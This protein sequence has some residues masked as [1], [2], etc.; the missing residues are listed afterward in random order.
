MTT[1]L[2]RW[3]SIGLAGMVACGIAAGQPSSAAGKPPDAAVDARVLLER[4]RA[5]L[6]AGDRY[7]ALGAIAQA[8]RLQPDNA[9]VAQA[10]ADVLVELG[11]P[12]AAAQVLGDRA[13][14]GV[15]S[16]VAGQRLRWAI[17]LPPPS[18]DPRRRFDPVDAALAGLDELLME[19]RTATPPDPGLVTRLQRD[20]AV[21]LRHRERWQEAVDQVSALRAAGDSPPAYV[22]Q[23]DADALLA[24]RRPAQARSAYEEALRRL[25]PSQQAD[26]DVAWRSL[27]MGRAYA[28]SESEDFGAAFGTVDALLAA[29]GP[30]WR[31]AGERQ[32]PRENDAWLEAKAFDAA[33]HSYADMPAAAWTRIEPLERGAPALPWLRAQASDIAAQQGWPRRAEDGIDSAAALAP[34]D[35]GLRVQQVDSDTRRHRLLRA[36]ERLAPLLE[37]GADLPRV[38][39]VRRELDAAI[40]PSVRFALGGRHADNQA[41]QGPGNGG[42]ASLQV[43][44]STF[45]GV[46]R[47]IGLADS[48]SDSLE[49]GRAKRHRFGGGAQALWP[50]W[51]LDALAWSQTGSL[52]TSG[53][54]LAAQWQPTDH[55]TFLAD[56]AKHSPD[57]PLRADFHGITADAVRG[58]LRY[59]WNESTEAGLKA[60]FMDFSDGNRRE[61]VT[62]D[63]ALSLLDRPHL[64]VLLKP[65]LEWQRNSLA[66]TPY[67]NPKESWLPSIEAQVQHV[68]W[69]VYERVLLQRLRLT[70]GM[71]DQRAFGARTVGGAAYEQTWRHD[72][73]TELTWGIEWASNVYNGQRERTLN[74]YLKLEHRFG[75]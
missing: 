3:R 18:P 12:S 8:R 54:S 75:R 51:R 16:R 58:G 47:L 38:Q 11:A 55:W 24:L 34:E 74:G 28:E 68:M 52:N 61:Q 65:R 27:M 39:Q 25:P 70:V 53:G 37:Q 36:D 7:A 40:G 45:A 56:A 9:E 48:S 66:V 50:D 19:A 2:R 21:A 60:Q 14:P 4:G 5:L 63:G 22:L 26:D 62:I 44:S 6:R 67:F 29:A 1:G 23:A 17:E 30:P 71:F 33:I 69:R 41:L 43:E 20:R 42:E 59:A 32:T 73:W 64:D 57:A 10:L 31:R 13:D 46:W 72:P 49:E 35:F 15:R